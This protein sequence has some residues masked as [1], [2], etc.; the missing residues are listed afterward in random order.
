MEGGVNIEMY[1][2]MA[3]GREEVIEFLSRCLTSQLCPVGGMDS[4][5][6]IILIDSSGRI[7]VFGV[8]V[9]HVFYLGENL[10]EAFESILRGG[11][12]IPVLPKRDY[13]QVHNWDVFEP[14][15]PHVFWVDSESWIC[16]TRSDL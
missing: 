8:E 1:P 9:E 7:F 11:E 13:S 14:G 3:G 15:A 6:G 16:E 10:A 12:L 4:N 5:N 2:E